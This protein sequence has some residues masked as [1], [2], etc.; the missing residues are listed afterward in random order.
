MHFLN[1][2]CKIFT[3]TLAEKLQKLIGDIIDRDQL[4]Y[5]KDRLI[6]ETI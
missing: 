5:I 2:D 4:G 3:K 1:T 6:G